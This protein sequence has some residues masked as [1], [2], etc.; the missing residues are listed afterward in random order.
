M[1]LCDR[2]RGP[3]HGL[4]GGGVLH[5]P[6]GDERQHLGHCG[7]GAHAVHPLYPTV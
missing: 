7:Q 5:L 1:G 3:L 6:P 4:L 2:L